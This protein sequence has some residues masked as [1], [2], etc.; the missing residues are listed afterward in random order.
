VTAAVDRYETSDL[1]ERLKAALRVT[2][3]LIT[4]PTSLSPE[5]VAD[6]RARLTPDELAELCLDVS[7]WSTQ[8]VHVAL[9]TDAPDRLPLGA[10]GVSWFRFDSD[11]R[12]AGFSDRPETG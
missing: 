4:M 7:K 8:K 11:G 12:V 1:D 5:A 10:D 2:D 6:A 3:A 9:G